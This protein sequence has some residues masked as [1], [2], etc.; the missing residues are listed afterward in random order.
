MGLLQTDAAWAVVGSLTLKYVPYF[1][2]LQGAEDI[3]DHVQEKGADQE[4]DTDG[5]G[6]L[7]VLCMGYL[8][9]L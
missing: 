3:H 6:E 2:D 9:F 5:Q 8:S 1:S 7:C 4:T